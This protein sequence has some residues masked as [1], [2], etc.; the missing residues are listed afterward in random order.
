MEYLRN[1]GSAAVSTLVQKSGINLPFTL[2][3][4]VS[5][6]ATLWTLHDATKRDDGTPVSVFEYDL[7][8]PLNKST[9]PLAKNVLRKL[10]TIRHPDILKFMDVVES[11]SAIFIMTERVRPLQNA[12]QAM[13]SRG[14]QE[15]EEWLLWGL[16]RISVALAFINDSASST[17]GNVCPK[18]IFI[19]PSGEWKLG[20]FEVLSSPRDD[21]ATMGG[22]LPEAMSCASP[23]VKKSGWSALKNEPVHAADSY[24]LGLLLHATFNPTD[25]PPAT[26]Q[27]PHPPPQPSSRGAIPQSV[28]PSFR[29]LL[30]PNPKTRMSP[31]VF[32]DIGMAETA[33]EGSGFFSDNRLVKVCGGL[34][35]FSL[36]SDGEK[37]ALIRMLKESA[38]SFPPEF[39]AFRVLPSLVSALEFGGASAASI[40]P[41]ILQFGKNVPPEDY[42][43][44][45]LMPLVKLYAN[46]DRGMRMAL[47]DSLPEYVEKLEKKVVVDQVWPHLQTGFSDTVAVIRE[48][49]VRAIILLSSKLNDRILNNDLLRHLAR[50]QNDPEASIRTNTCI[51]IGR[52]GPT[53]GYNTKR[54]VLIP[55]FSRALKDPFVHARVAGLMAFM[56]TSDCYDMEDVAGKVIPNV[57]GATLEKEKIVR[58]Q[59]FK[60][61]ELFIKKLEAHAA[62][63]VRLLQTSI[64]SSATGAAGTLASWAITSIGRKLAPNDLQSTISSGAEPLVAISPAADTTRATTGV[65]PG[66]LQPKGLRLGANKPNIDSIT[67]QVFDEA[68]TEDNGSWANDAPHDVF[69]DGDWGAFESAPPITSP[70]PK[71]AIRPGLGFSSS[72]IVDWGSVLSPISVSN[73]KRPLSNPLSITPQLQIDGQ[74]T[75]GIVPSFVAFSPASSAR[76]TPV[77]SPALVDSQKER[78]I[79][80]ISKEEKAAEMARRKEE[81]RLR[82]EKLKEQKKNTAAAAES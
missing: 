69:A 45:V 73:E 67:A 3:S 12:L 72:N 47:L 57:A 24:A 32:L 52:L 37:E 23:E 4:K 70:V 2:G 51:L 78:A 36:S 1:L 40:V 77:P 7:I 9:L 74:R 63:M 43:R 76:P 31:K 8:H 29:K 80:P 18:S 68:S 13:P 27:P 53:L 28:F 34:D 17:H 62:T 75:S 6:C 54:K 11:D 42:P 16:H 81:R 64:V 5:S 59:A 61:L 10:R 22:L 46:P 66:S 71:P 35:H 55:A 58:D 56:A 15:R 48:A 79:K 49:T 25:P 20:G 41:L 50:M 60:A 39:A 65:S 38:S 14:S 26:L 21:L 82:I 44:T 30:N 33:G 19:T